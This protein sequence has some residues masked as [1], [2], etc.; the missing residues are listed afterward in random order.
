MANLAT[1]T[2]RGA[3]GGG[4][5][6]DAITA[7]SCANSRMLTNRPKH[8][9]LLVKYENVILIERSGPCG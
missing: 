2:A 4:A 6:T 3:V 1:P 8:G 9:N 7:P 5:A